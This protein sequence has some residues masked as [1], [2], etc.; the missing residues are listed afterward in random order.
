LGKK[1]ALY[2]SPAEF[3][4]YIHLHRLKPARPAISGQKSR[5]KQMG[6]HSRDTGYFRPPKT[7][8]NTK[9]KTAIT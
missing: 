5:L 7:G 6:N 3:D 9:T 2:R 4:R 1:G 8:R